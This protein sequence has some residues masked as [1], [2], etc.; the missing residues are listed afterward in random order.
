MATDEDYIEQ[1]DFIKERENFIERTGQT[2]ENWLI[3]WYNDQLPHN[4]ENYSFLNLACFIT[5]K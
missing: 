4:A 2:P 3:S 5:Y 1:F